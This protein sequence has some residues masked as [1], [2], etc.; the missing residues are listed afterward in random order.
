MNTA[1][2]CT[3][4]KRRDMEEKEEREKERT[5]VIVENAAKREGVEGVARGRGH[6][7]KGQ[8]EE[9]M[10]KGIIRRGYREMGRRGYGEWGKRKRVWGKGQDE[11]GMGKGNEQGME[12]VKE[13]EGIEKGARGRG[14]GGKSQEEQE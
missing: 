9:D 10:G 2:S 11:E 1:K 5:E 3:G 8:E 4:R 6:E 13:G 7:K 14:H 12:K